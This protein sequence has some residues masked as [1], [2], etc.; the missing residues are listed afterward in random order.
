MIQVRHL[1]RSG[2]EADEALVIRDVQVR[3]RDELFGTPRRYR[4]TRTHRVRRAK[5][6]A[7]PLSR[8]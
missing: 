6:R 2:G 1:Y 5:L 3:E 4:A 7:D 8:I